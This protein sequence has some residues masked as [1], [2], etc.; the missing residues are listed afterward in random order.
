M[1]H[2]IVAEAF[3]PN[4]SNLPCVNHKDGNK[5]NNCVDNLEWV[6]FKQNSIHAVK[7]GLIKTG[8][9][10]PMYGKTGDKHPCHYSNLGNKWN[11]GR[12]C[13]QETRKKIAAKLKGNK[14]NLGYRHSPE[15][16]E[17][18]RITALKREALKKE[19]RINEKI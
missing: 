5:L 1:V 4:P 11:V 19:R 3:I 7:T 6:T 2:R 13:K 10:S 12:T 9:D 18:M 17:K 8:K 16:R 14:N 15:T